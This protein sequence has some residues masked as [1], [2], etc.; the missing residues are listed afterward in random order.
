MFVGNISQ[1]WI[2]LYEESV[3]LNTNKNQQSHS[4]LWGASVME[5]ILSKFIW[6]WEIR[7]KEVHGKTKER[8]ETLQ[9]KK[10]TIETKRLNSMKNEARPGNWFLF[11]ENV[12]E[13]IKKSS[14]KRIGSRVCSHYNA[15]KNSVKKWRTTSIVD[16]IWNVNST[17]TIDR[18]YYQQHKR[19]MDGRQ[20]ER[21]RIPTNKNQQTITNYQLLFIIF[22]H[23]N[24]FFLVTAVLLAV[25]K[26]S[27]LCVSLLEQSLPLTN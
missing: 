20:K 11:H 16:W 3:W 1:E 10:L 15:I 19:W 13:F 24:S 27:L 22:K 25:P 4:Y 14:A 8:N 7:N 17:K 2:K 5:V 12:D 21:R 26:G 18:L 9:K 6:L 23:L